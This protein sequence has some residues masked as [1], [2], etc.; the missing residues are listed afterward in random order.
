MKKLIF[1]V[2]LLLASC[3]R[4]E[5]KVKEVINPLVASERERNPHH[6]VFYAERVEDTYIEN[7]GPVATFRFIARK[8]SPEDKYILGSQNLGQPIQPYAWYEV[9]DDGQLGRQIDSATLMLDSE[10]MLMFDY[11]MGEPVEYW[12]CS[13][14][15]TSRL[16]VTLVPYPIMSE[17]QD[18][19]TITL[20]RLTPDARL[21]LLE[22]RDF[23]P[24]EQIFVSS[25]S[26]KQHTHNVPI[27][28][29]NGKFTMIFEPG[30]AERSGGSAYIDVE[31]IRERLMLKYDWGC[32]AVNPKKRLANTQKIK[33]DAL[34]KLPTDW[35]D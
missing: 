20:R 33:R 34:I 10:M 26:G 1:L 15:G 32:E 6:S 30:I 27:I 29:I 31:R 19:A 7:V 18:G 4:P 17:G 25:Q 16:G 28:C 24:D 3:Q 14:D 2:L 35:K 13:L 23:D 8:F 12:L 5:P 11:F 22:G 9:D 21:V